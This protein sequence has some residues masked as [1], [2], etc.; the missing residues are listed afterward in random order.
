[1]GTR[2]VRRQVFKVKKQSR[3]KAAE[4]SL[5]SPLKSVAMPAPGLPFAFEDTGFDAYHAKLLRRVEILEREV[6]HEPS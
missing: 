1:V 3:N 6:I 2:K 4:H 5:L